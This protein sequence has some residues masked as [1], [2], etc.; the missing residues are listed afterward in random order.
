ML[1]SV[2]DVTV[3]ELTIKSGLAVSGD[4]GVGVASAIELERYS[5][6]HSLSTSLICTEG[7]V[8]LSLLIKKDRLSDERGAKFRTALVA[9]LDL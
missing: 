4:V 5:L 2:N 1:S 3:S 6:L 9:I 7:G 8:C